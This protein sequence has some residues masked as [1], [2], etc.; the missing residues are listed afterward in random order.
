MFGRK[1]F[2]WAE[3]KRME[4]PFFVMLGWE[5]KIFH[6][7]FSRLLNQSLNNRL[8]KILPPLRIPTTI[9]LQKFSFI[10]SNQQSHQKSASRFSDFLLPLTIITIPTFH[11]KGQIFLQ[12][13]TFLI[14]RF[15]P[16]KIPH[17]KHII[18]SKFIFSTDNHHHRHP[19][20]I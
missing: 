14:F 6:I 4:F 12:K 18:S 7:I 15:S 9:S 5:K 20:F 17:T 19:I 13:I 1:D 8:P 11:V 16:T 3:A 10:I 2:G